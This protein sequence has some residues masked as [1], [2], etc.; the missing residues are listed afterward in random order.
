MHGI[1]GVLKNHERVATHPLG[2]FQQLS[3]HCLSKAGTR[4]YDAKP[5]ITLQVISEL[6]RLTEEMADVPML[7]RTHGQTASPTTMGK[8]MANVAYR[9][10]RQ[11]QQV[12]SNRLCKFGSPRRLHY[13]PSSRGKVASL[14]LPWLRGISSRLHSTSL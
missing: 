5:Y 10:M 1:S 9:L 3:G 13:I 4:H 12:N 6:G 11:R 2:P 7:A 14:G 8:E